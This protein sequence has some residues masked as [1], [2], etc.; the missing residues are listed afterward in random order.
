[1]VAT[2]TSSSEA[3]VCALEKFLVSYLDNYANPLYISIAYS[4]V[5]P[6]EIQE[7]IT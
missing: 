6:L 2:I 4:N 1:M 7:E 5:N 3:L